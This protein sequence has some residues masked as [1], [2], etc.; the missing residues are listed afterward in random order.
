MGFILFIAATGAY[1]YLN[2][3]RIYYSVSYPFISDVGLWSAMH[4]LSPFD[5]GIIGN[6]VPSANDNTGMV[7]LETTGFLCAKTVGFSLTRLT[8]NPTMENWV[9]PLH[10]LK[11]IWK[12]DVDKMYGMQSSGILSQFLPPVDDADVLAIRW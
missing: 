8:A 7:A 9:S 12:K 10:W 3:A 1:G 4:N 11:D 6:T 2:I 5:N